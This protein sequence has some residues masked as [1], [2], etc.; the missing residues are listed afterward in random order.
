MVAFHAGQNYPSRMKR[1]KMPPVLAGFGHKVFITQVQRATA[2]KAVD[3]ASNQNLSRHTRAAKQGASEGGCSGLAVNSGYTSRIKTSRI[4]SQSVG[5]FTDRNAAP[6][7][8]DN[9]RIFL[10]RVSR[11][12]D[13]HIGCIF[14]FP[15]VFCLKG[16]VKGYPQFFQNVIGIKNFLAIRA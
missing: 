7:G 6:S 14:P 13:N 8:L 12:M 3:G 4:R 9:L 1:Q 11:R 5:I 16:F 10:G 2:L 15:D